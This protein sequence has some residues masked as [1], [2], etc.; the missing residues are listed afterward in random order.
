MPQRQ[1]Y[2][3]QLRRKSTILK[4]LS[5]K[6]TIEILLAL[7][8]GA[9]FS[10]LKWSLGI[11]A[12]TLSARLQEFTKRGLIIKTIYAEVPVR[13][14]YSLTEKGAKLAQ[15]ITAIEVLEA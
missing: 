5:K 11:S 1:V 3:Q 8:S 14:E 10:E 6:W 4:L 7:R 13:V 2:V 9:R 15:I 12:K